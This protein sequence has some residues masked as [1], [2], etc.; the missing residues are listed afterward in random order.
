MQLILLGP[1]GAGKG[2]QAKKLVDKLRLPQISTGD[3]LRAAVRDQTEL[4]MKAK[5][6]MDAGQ[7]VPDDIVIAMVRERLQQDDC[8]PGFILD[9]F[10]RAVS[11]AEALDKMLEDMGRG[12]DHV[13]SIEVPEAELVKRLTGRRS[14]PDC[15]AMF[16]VEFNPPRQEGICD[17]CGGKLIIRDDDKEETIRQRIAVY[18]EQTEPLKG[19]YESRGLLRRIAG[20]GTP[21]QVEALIDEVVGKA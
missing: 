5:A 21:R 20:S 17:K 9:G 1:P 10:P 12:L 11:Q 13:L 4:G 15:G 2:T 7:L 18:R 16:H 19:Y 14:C 3:L 6:K 8:R